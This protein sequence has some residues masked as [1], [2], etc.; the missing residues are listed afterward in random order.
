MLA[1]RAQLGLEHHRLSNAQGGWEGLTGGRGPPLG[2]SLLR[3]EAGGPR[4]LLPRA[5]DHRPLIGRCV[6]PCPAP[7]QAPAPTWSRAF[8]SVILVSYAQLAAVL[9]N[10]TCSALEL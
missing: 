4:H 7:A 2:I 1:S 10:I 3:A 8:S 6:L 5:T 9:W